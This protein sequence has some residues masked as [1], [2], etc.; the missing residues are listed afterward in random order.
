MA[1]IKQQIHQKEGLLKHIKVSKL[2]DAG[3]RLHDQIKYLKKKLN[4]LSMYDNADEQV[5]SNHASHEISSSN[6]ICRGLSEEPQCLQN[7]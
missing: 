7:Q 3:Q 6:N 2:P 5:T 4:T 1:K